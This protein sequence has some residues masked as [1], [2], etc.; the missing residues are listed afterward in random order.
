MARIR[1]VRTPPRSTA[2]P[3]NG[4]FGYCAATSDKSWI[5]EA[6][7]LPPCA[8]RVPRLWQIPWPMNS[9]KRVAAPCRPLAEI[10][11]H[12]RSSTRR[13]TPRKARA[14]FP[15][16][17]R[18]PGEV[19][20]RGVDDL[21]HLG[22]RG[23]LL[24]SLARLGEEPRVLHRDD[25]LCRE[26]LQQR[27]LFVGERADL[28]AVDRY[29]PP[30]TR[31]LCAADRTGARA[32]EIDQCARRSD[33]RCDKPRRPSD[34]QYGR[35]VRPQNRGR[36]ES[37]GVRPDGCDAPVCNRPAAAHA[38]PAESA[39]RRKSRDAESGARTAASPFRASRRTPAPGRRARN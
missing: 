9:Q 39:R 4:L 11:H 3:G 32:A 31:R 25:R 12:H 19:A 30:A 34:R 37:P 28:L 13:M 36:C 38:Q 2:A 26:I 14:P 8:R 27:D 1:K 6:P 22:G 29:V 23:L 15:R 17:R 35:S 24:Q 21:Q 18:T 20:G 5:C 16:S 10:V 33:R 7:P